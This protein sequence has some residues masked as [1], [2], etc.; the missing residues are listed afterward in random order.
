MSI[1]SNVKILLIIVGIMLFLLIISSKNFLLFHSLAE[2]I[3]TIVMLSIM[4]IVLPMDKKINNHFIFWIG[5]SFVFVSLFDIGHILTY[6][7]VN[8]I[9]VSS[10]ITAKLWMAARYWQSIALLLGLTFFKKEFNKSVIV[11]IQTLIF[12]L[13]MLSI[14]FTDFFPSCYIEGSGVTLFKVISEFV[15]VIILA[16]SMFYFFKHKESWYKDF[17]KYIQLTILLFLSSEIFFNINPDFYTFSNIIGHLLK[18]LSVIFFY[19]GIYKSVITR[20]YNLLYEDISKLNNEAEKLK[21]DLKE[22][23]SSSKVDDMTGTFNRNYFD[24]F[25]NKFSVSNYSKV[26]L[27]ILDIDN[28]KLINDSYGH[29]EGD[30]VIRI[31]SDILKQQLRKGDLVF[32]FGGDEFVIIITDESEMVVKNVI[33]RIE[34]KFDE[35]NKFNEIKMSV[36]CGYQYWSNLDDYITFDEMFTQADAKMYVKK[37]SKLD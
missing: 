25:S 27:I 15:I 4:L 11:Y 14:I 10:D 36:S 23:S 30:K 9:D 6:K 19:I 20:P 29:L 13:I 26:G 17:Y 5:V 16:V 3:S 37:N 28:L 31:T 1:K 35:I 8:I 33:G 2:L 7:G 32:R 24:E 22:V 18:V 21:K 34:K 12:V